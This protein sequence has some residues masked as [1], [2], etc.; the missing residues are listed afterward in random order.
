MA[1]LL[2]PKVAF[3]PKHSAYI[4]KSK[5]K[6][7]PYTCKPG[8]HT[9]LVVVPDF[10]DAVEIARIV[11]SHYLHEKEWPDIS[12]DRLRVKL[13]DSIPTLLS[14]HSIDPTDVL[15]Y[16]IDRNLDACIINSVKYSDEN[17][18]MEC[19]LI[20]V[21]VPAHQYLDSLERIFMLD[22]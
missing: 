7:V 14:I 20:P 15:Q 1:T 12:K 3:Y 22:V 9:A 13:I 19:E 5:S 18:K 16:C 17:I 8:N 11:E 2:V 6:N 21:V 4:I 10:Q